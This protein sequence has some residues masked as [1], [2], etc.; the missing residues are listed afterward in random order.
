MIRILT[1]LFAVMLSLPVL[2]ERA[3]RGKPIALS[4]DKASFDD[5]SQTYLLE[6]NVFLVKGTMIIKGAKANVKVDP[7]GY[8]LADVYA[9]PGEVATLK[10]K[11][12]SGIEE[13][14]QGFADWIQYDAKKESATL[15][16][17]AKM[18]Q[19]VKTKVFDEIVGDKIYYDAIAE[20]Y[21]ATSKNN[22]KSVLSPRRN[23]KQNP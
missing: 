19:L 14:V 8:Q 11:K 15:T 21:S 13:Y 5:V 2:A 7:E 16:G 10:Q 4:S 18:W 3:D 12:D 17:N 23:Q 6:E 22:V 1:I 20:T 9:K